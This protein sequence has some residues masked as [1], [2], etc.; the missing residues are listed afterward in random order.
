MNVAARIGM[1]SGGT[2]M[3]TARDYVR[4]GLIAMWDGIENAGYGTHDPNAT[5]WKDL[6]GNGYDLIGLFSWAQNA[7]SS[8]DTIANP[9]LDYIK[10]HF[11]DSGFSVCV[12]L[13]VSVPRY[14]RGV[15]N[16]L[17]D[18]IDGTFAIRSDKNAVA[19]N[20]TQIMYWM[21]RTGS[22]RIILG[23]GGIDYELSIYQIFDNFKSKTILN[24]LNRVMPANYGT[25]STPYVGNVTSANFVFTPGIKIHN[26]Y[27]YERPLSDAEIAANYAIDKARFGLT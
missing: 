24:N 7:S 5:V 11:L 17:T 1:W 9:F 4:D 14:N 8:S 23:R 21:P 3:P 26:L 27:F 12:N 2:K 10:D 18:G 16:I 13:I 20:E 25:K 22:Q 19:E 6:S 15:Y